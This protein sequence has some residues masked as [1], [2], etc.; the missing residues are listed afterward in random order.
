MSVA[1]IV[2]APAAFTVIAH[3]SLLAWIVW[4]DEL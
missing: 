2:L 4:S 3:L 1:M